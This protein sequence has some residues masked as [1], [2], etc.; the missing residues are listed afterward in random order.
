M[1]L[2]ATIDLKTDHDGMA[3]Y[4]GSMSAGWET[5]IA[6]G[7]IASADNSGS[8]VLIPDSQVVGATNRIFRRQRG[9]GTILRIRVGYDTT[10]TSITS[11]VFNVFG[12][13]DSNSPWQR[14]KNLN[15]D[16][17]VTVTLSTAADV[18]VGSLSYSHPDRLVHSFDID[19]CDEFLIG[20]KTALAGST[21][22][23]TSAILQAK[24]I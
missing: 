24:V 10:L 23:T 18:V 5:V 19:G 4:P 11:P 15:G 13:K 14:L 8:T 1:T 3:T 21:G 9:R 12:R 20:T 2:A 6:A 7:G 22:V 17:D 16:T